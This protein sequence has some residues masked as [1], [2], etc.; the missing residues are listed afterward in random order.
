MT[1]VGVYALGIIK[2]LDEGTVIPMDDDYFNENFAG[3][4]RVVEKTMSAFR[5]YFTERLNNRGNGDLNLVELGNVCSD[6]PE[7]SCAVEQQY[8]RITDLPGFLFETASLDLGMLGVLKGEQRDAYMARILE[9]EA[10]NDSMNYA[11]KGLD[12]RMVYATCLGLW[13]AKLKL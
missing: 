9:Q 5:N 6:V 8:G 13:E 2:K 12:P 1:N 7:I 3:S 11:A 4:G 10:K